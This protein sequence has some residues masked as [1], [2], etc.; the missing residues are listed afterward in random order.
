MTTPAAGIDDRL[1]SLLTPRMTK[2]VPHQPTP[3]QAAFLVLPQ[4]EAFYGGAA[5][6]GK[7]DALLMAAL[8][9][10]D[11]PDYA[12]IIFRK[13]YSDL[14]LPGALL[15][16]AQ[17]WLAPTDAAWNGQDKVWTF[18]SGATLSFG[19]LDHEDQK[20]RYQSA[21]FNFVA[22]DELTQFAETQYRYL[23]SR[24]RR[25][26]ASGIPTRMRSA[27]NPGGVG[28][29]W[30]RQRFIVEGPSHGR[31]F[32]PAG[33]ADNPYLDQEDYRESLMELDPVTRAQLLNGDWGAKQQG[34]MFR[35]DWFEIVDEMPT[36]VMGDRKGQAQVIASVRHWDLAATEVDKAKSFVPDWTV[37]L[38]LTLTDEGLFYVED[39]IRVQMSPRNVEKLIGNT[40]QRDGKYRTVIQ[41][42]QE[43]GSAGAH[44]IDHYRRHVLL[45]YVFRGAKPSGSKEVRAQ[46]VSSAAEGGLIKLC[47]GAWINT[48]IDE[49]EA[50]PVSEFKD[51]VDTL[52][53]SF[54]YVSK[55][56]RPKRGKQQAEVR[57]GIWS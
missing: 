27:A 8:Q 12:A 5:G 4:K 31:I 48:F 28:H 54:Q 29:E 32:I 20:Y 2:Y 37:G 25:D 21:Q 35:R 18:P 53:A 57:R 19:Y 44:V 10:V 56:Y 46:P 40:A 43:P 45:G 13:T 7:S 51:Q 38:K 52:S 22:F 11:K 30:V 49:V 34:G 47:R 41:M 9:Y 24:M 16:R 26:A 50:F 23:F 6:G 17:R 36:R 55:R 1:R 39:V 15:E 3:K 42:E 14:A 33:L